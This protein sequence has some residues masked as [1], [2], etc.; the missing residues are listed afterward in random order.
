MREKED[1]VI[2]KI[3]E[4]AIP[5]EARLI[6]HCLGIAHPE[7]WVHRWIRGKSGAFLRPLCTPCYPLTHT[8][9]LPGLVDF[10]GL[11]AESLVIYERILSTW[12]VAWLAVGS[13]VDLRIPA[14]RRLD[15]TYCF[16]SLTE[17]MCVDELASNLRQAV[18]IASMH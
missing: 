3:V 8:E 13:E 10:S 7:E 5:R 12:P 1:R 18:L 14:V 16:G 2:S 15:R 11:T 4:L 9:P 17:G 6:V